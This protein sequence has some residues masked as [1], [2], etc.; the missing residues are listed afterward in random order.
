MLRRTL[1]LAFCFC[2]PAAWAAQTVDYVTLDPDSGRFDCDEQARAVCRERTD[3]L[4]RLDDMLAAGESMRRDGD[5]LVFAHRAAAD[6]VVLRGGLQYPLSRVA[7]SDRWSLVLRVARLDELAF[8]R[9][10]VEV[11]GAAF[12]KLPPEAWQGPRA[13]PPPPVA[14][15]LRG[16]LRDHLLPSLHLPAARLITSYEPP[17]PGDPV[18]VVYLADGEALPG[19]ARYLEPAIV[20]GRLPHLLLVGLH[21]AVGQERNFEYVAGIRRGQARFE[22]HERFFV[23]QVLPYAERELQAPAAP[24]ARVLAGASNGADWAVEIALRHPARFGGVVA[25]SVAWPPAPAER[26]VRARPVRFQ[27][28]AGELES[29][30]L[31]TTRELHAALEAAGVDAELHT[32][33]GGHDSYWWTRQFPAALARL[34]V[35]PKPAR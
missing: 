18:A 14:A 28:A 3:D 34:G 31:Q 9:G 17:L 4:A 5:R 29:T 23:E 15:P 19:Y 32:L 24:A 10:L 16:T 13:E 12:E 22:A 26:L 2:T 21:A 1:F 33:L 20:A 6:A 7:D 25:F 27:L 11:R 35:A 30:F 8:E